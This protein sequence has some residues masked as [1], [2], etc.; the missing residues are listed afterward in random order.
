LGRPDSVLYCAPSLTRLVVLSV[1][2]G[3]DPMGG[4]AKLGVLAMSVVV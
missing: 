3:L 2:A 1:R 4:L